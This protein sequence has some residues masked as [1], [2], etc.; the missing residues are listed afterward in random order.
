M[1]DI[2]LHIDK[3]IQRVKLRVLLEIQFEAIENGI[4]LN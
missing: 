2:T 4:Y 1:I 3:L